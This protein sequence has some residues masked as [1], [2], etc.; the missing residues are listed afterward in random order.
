MTTLSAPIT[1]VPSL[2]R[3]SSSLS[4]EVHEYYFV[5]SRVASSSSLP[6]VGIEVDGLLREITVV[7]TREA[8]LNGAWLPGTLRALGGLPW[9]GDNW[10][11]VGSKRTDEKAVSQILSLLLAI[12]DDNAPTPSVVP[13][14]EGGVQVEWH[15][16]H[17]DL[18]I[19]AMPSG[20]VE[21][22]YHGPDGECEERVSENDLDEVRQLAHKLVSVQAPR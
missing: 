15:R 1:R 7:V 10:G 22:F 6:S 12:L 14:W 4:S 11:S 8:N 9:G 5:P 17:I 3:D 19:E 18:E 2:A 13:T 20:S 16:N 21:Y